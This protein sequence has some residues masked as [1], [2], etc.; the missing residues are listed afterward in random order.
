ML[1]SFSKPFRELLFPLRIKSKLPIMAFKALHTLPLAHFNHFLLI[2][3]SLNMLRFRAFARALASLGS[4]ALLLNPLN[5]LCQVNSLFLVTS[6]SQK[7]HLC[8][9]HPTQLLFHKACSF[10]HC[11]TIL[12]YLLYSTQHSLKLFY[13]SDCL[14]LFL[15]F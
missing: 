5:L 11:D 4:N 10:Q 2:F 3:Y 12:F 13:E 6:P 9:S 1:L 7:G 14:C 8:Q 15:L